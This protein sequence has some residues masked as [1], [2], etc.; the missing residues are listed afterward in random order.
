MAKIIPGGRYLVNGRLVNANGE[1][2][3]E[4][5]AMAPE[6]SIPVPE[7]AEESPV[8]S[9]PLTAAQKRAAARAAA[10]AG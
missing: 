2:I 7:G 5:E 3:I 6:E 4:A 9:K 8:P 1:P 10:E